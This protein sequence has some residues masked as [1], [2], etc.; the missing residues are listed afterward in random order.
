MS[1][2]CLYVKFLKGRMVERINPNDITRDLDR[3]I[4]PHLPEEGVVIVDAG[5]VL[6]LAKSLSPEV[7]LRL[8]KGDQDKAKHF[9]ADIAQTLEILITMVK[10]PGGEIANRVEYVKNILDKINH[11]VLTEMLRIP[12]FK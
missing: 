6:K 5:L 2:L 3:I 4:E 9:N 10:A 11:A 7:T 8:T 12:F 1:F